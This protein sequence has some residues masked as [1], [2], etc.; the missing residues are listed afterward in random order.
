MLA[1]ESSDRL[2]G[3]VLGGA[4]HLVGCIGQGGM[5]A[6]YEAHHLRLQK[7]VAV[8]LMRRAM[9]K[10]QEAL[11]RFHREATVASRLGHPNLVNVIDFGTSDQGEPYLV[12]DYLE[13]EDLD[14]R[15]R[16]AGAVPLASVVSIVRQA[17]SALAAMHAKG[18]IHRD[19]KPANVF[20]VQVPGE[21][22][23]VKVLD[24][25]VSKM[26]ACRTKLTG[27]ATMI[28]TPEYMSPEQASGASEEVDARTDQ[29][30]LACIV[31]EMLAGRAP[32]R[33]D[34]VNAVF[35][36]LINLDPPPLSKYAPTLPSAVE[37]VL[38]RAL[39]KRPA[40][41]YASIKE[42]ARALEMAAPGSWTELTPM[43]V[44]CTNVVGP[45]EATPAA[46]LQPSPASTEDAACD[47]EV[48]DLDGAKPRR[49]RLQL[50]VLGLAA[51]IVFSVAG[52]LLARA[53]SGGAAPSP[54]A[55][56]ATARVPN[57]KT[58]PVAPPVASDQPQPTAAS[59][60]KSAL[61]GNRGKSRNLK[62]K[63][64]SFE[65]ARATPST[66]SA[67]YQ[68]GGARRKRPIF[69]EL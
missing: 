35:Y 43:P 14:R 27:S 51:A 63:A 46:E 22:D 68:A 31:W 34:D 29:W 42:F 19:L 13:G 38:L 3:I 60:S 67:R 56:A 30:A 61:P 39:S 54:S 36:Q 18:I 45:R 65:D 62:S 5:G 25:G 69:E 10:N 44:A 1:E 16:R 55:K 28:G 53:G 2:A 32:F 66:T 33:A 48:L 37:P 24:F 58:L 12:M 7:R 64:D 26:R 21:P 57:V 41:R 23:F 9:A 59:A 49:S 11:A 40:D 4:Y 8:K 15:L 52:A 20:L 47:A 50:A 17:A 6:V